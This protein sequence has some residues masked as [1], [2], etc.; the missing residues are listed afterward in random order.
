MKHDAKA[1][2][3]TGLFILT[4]I[5]ILVLVNLIGLEIFGRVDLT[6]NRMYS[7][8]DAS[9]ETMRRLTDQVRAKAYF[10]ADLPAPYNSNARYLRDLF[11]EYAAYSDGRFQ[12]EFLDPG[13]DD[14]IKNDMMLLGIP[15]VQ[16][17]VLED[18]KFQVKQ[19]F[20]GIVFYY[21]DKKEVIPLVRTTD[22]LEYEI[23]ST[24]RK[25][26]AERLRI[27]GFTQGH[28]EPAPREAMRSVIEVIE[29]H[30]QVQEVDLSEPS[31]GIP[32]DVETLLVIGPTENFSEGALYQIDQFLMKGRTVAFLYDTVNVDLQQFRAMNKET[33]LNR[34]LK[35]YGITVNQNLI[36]D[37]Q[38]QQ[39]RFRTGQGLLMMNYP[40]IP[41]ISDFNR[42]NVLV[43][44]LDSLAL[45]FVSSLT[46]AQSTDELSYSVLARTSE[47]SF[48][49][50][51]AYQINPLQ[52][53]NPSPDAEMGPFPVIASAEGVFGSHFAHMETSDPERTYMDPARTL[54]TSAPTRIL[55]VGDGSFPTDQLGD[56]RGAGAVFFASMVDWLLQDPAMISIRS[57]GVATRP[58]KELESW[59]RDA[60]KWGNIVGIP[61]LFIL[62]GLL[63]FA[64]LRARRRSLTASSNS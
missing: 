18:D 58:L 60:I 26:V 29:K 48:L 62:F 49:Q 61:A 39:M 53:E 41:I 12:F 22:G 19:A 3:S 34:L 24:V 35:T 1:T 13:E 23:T 27:V 36:A 7:L 64:L 47:R 63:R 42:D 54:K 6:E 40:F 31:R 50:T 15:P 28:G 51:G 33:G 16:I 46:I 37:V 11:E 14:K 30:H 32:A 21:L 57:R 17:Q 4:V 5:G 20:M 55:V 25:L 2:L 44:T 10:T 59:Q 43:G 52:L 9:K 38:C 56:P 45:P 8:S